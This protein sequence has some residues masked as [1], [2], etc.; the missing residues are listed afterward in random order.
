[1]EASCIYHYIHSTEETLLKDFLEIF[2]WSECVY[3]Q[4]ALSTHYRIAAQSKKTVLGV[5]EVMLGVLPG[6]GGT[7]RLQKLVST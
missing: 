7:Q 1:M 6:A 4:V 3:I 5:P 2:L